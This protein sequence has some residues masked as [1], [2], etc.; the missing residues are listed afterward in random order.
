M[1]YQTRDTQWVYT[2]PDIGGWWVV[3]NP[4]IWCTLKSSPKYFLKCD[5]IIYSD[6]LTGKEWA[7]EFWY[8]LLVCHEILKEV[9]HFI[10]SFLLSKDLLSTDYWRQ[11][12][13]VQIF[14]AAGAV[15]ECRNFLF[16][17]KTSQKFLVH[18]AWFVLRNIMQ[19]LWDRR[20]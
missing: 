10:L 9:R 3:L 17:Q 15:P 12:M 8:S 11:W 19:C 2:F 4:L 14:T 5:F 18:P 7:F 1:W 16:L 20:R 13:A 6:P